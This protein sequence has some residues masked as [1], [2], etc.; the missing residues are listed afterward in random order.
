MALK[1]ERSLS[2]SLAQL[3]AHHK[4]NEQTTKITKLGTLCDQEG[5]VAKGK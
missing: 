3:H 2:D 4:L 5:V 1:K